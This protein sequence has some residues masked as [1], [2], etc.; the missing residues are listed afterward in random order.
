M[1]GWD[2]GILTFRKIWFILNNLFQVNDAFGMTL[3][4][5]ALE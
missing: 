2:F 4:F 3:Q 1:Q 5:L